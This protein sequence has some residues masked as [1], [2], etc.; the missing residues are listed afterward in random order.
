M[1]TLKEKREE[2]REKYNSIP[3]GQVSVGIYL[4]SVGSKFVTLLNT[5]DTTTIEKIDIDDFYEN[6]MSE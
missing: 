5:W 3:E 6:Y 4:K 2:I 1:K